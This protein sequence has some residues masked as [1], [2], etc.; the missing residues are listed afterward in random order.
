MSKKGQAEL[1]GAIILIGLVV[2][3]G[4]SSYKLISENRYVGDISTKQ[5]YDLK[6][7]DT[8]QINPENIINFKDFE[9]VKRNGFSAAKCSE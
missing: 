7:C 2:L 5:Y 8:S 3:G 4:V 9:E 1:V 6:R